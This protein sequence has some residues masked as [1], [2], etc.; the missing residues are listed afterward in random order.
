VISGSEVNAD[1]RASHPKASSSI[2]T[3]TRKGAFRGPTRSDP[4]SAIT[5]GD[6]TLNVQVRAALL[7]IS[8]SSLA[9]RL[10]PEPKP[11]LLL[12]SAAAL[13]V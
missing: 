13:G 11:P 3:H 8:R 9:E 4:R 2:E 10:W 12:V 1:V 7:T 6:G 5:V